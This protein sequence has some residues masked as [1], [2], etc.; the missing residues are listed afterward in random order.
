MPAVAQGSQETA[1]DKAIFIAPEGQVE[2]AVKASL[3]D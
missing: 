2:G 3:G 1:F